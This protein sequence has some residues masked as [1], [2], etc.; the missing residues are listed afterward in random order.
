MNTL[1]RLGLGLRPTVAFSPIGAHIPRRHIATLQPRIHMHISKSREEG[2]EYA[3]QLRKEGL[4]VYTDGSRKLHGG[5]GGAARATIPGGTVVVTQYLG[6][7][8][9]YSSIEAEML[10]II[11]GVKIAQIF[12]SNTELT[13][14]SD[15]QPAIR[16]LLSGKSNAEYGGSAA[17]TACMGSGA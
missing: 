10:G 17:D 15:C 13:I 9:D 4:H 8:R 11:L 5:V 14:F 16:G 12:P 2:R 3:R 1:A 7:A 6:S